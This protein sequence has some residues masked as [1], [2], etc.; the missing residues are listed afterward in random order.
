MCVC[1][2]VGQS[3]LTFCDPMVVGS[4]DPLCMEFSR[5][6]HWSGTFPSARDF[7]NPEIEPRCPAL[8]AHSF[9][10]EPLTLQ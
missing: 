4:Q 3:C 2:L 8:Q 6:E 1:V 9:P 5:E 10:S 7:P